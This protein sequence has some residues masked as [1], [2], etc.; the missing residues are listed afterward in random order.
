MD[1]EGRLSEVLSE[2]ART[3]VTDFPIQAILDH[4]VGRI[5]NVLPITAAGVTLI[6]AGTDPHY[7][8][9]SDESALRFEKLQT[10]LGQ[11]PCV[12]AFESGEAVSIPDLSKDERFPQF[13]SAAW[14]EGLRAIF[15][16]PLRQGE[17]QLGALDLYRSSVGS[18][19]AQAMAAAQ[20]LAD[21]ASAY[22]L[23]AQA[24]ADLEQ[25]SELAVENSL[26]D[27]LTGLPNRALLVQRLDHAILRCR[28]SGKTVA[29]LYADLD[30]FKAVN[31][32]YGHHVG[33]EL[34]IAVSERLGGLLRPGDTLAR[35]SGD[36]FVVL[37]EDLDDVSQVNPIADRIDLA[38]TVPFDLAGVQ[39]R[40]SAS[41]GIAFAG[42]GND[43]PETVLQEA[44]TAMYQVKRQGGARHGIIDVREQHLTRHKDGLI[45]DLRL[46]LT[47]DELEIVYQ[48]IVTTVGQDLRGVE[49]LLRWTHPRLGAIPAET[50]VRL[51]EESGLITEIGRWVLTRACT[52][53]H[54]LVGS[55]GD[56]LVAAVN[57]SAHQ[58]SAPDFVETVAA[59]LTDTDTQPHRLTLE[60]TE[61][62]FIRESESVLVALNALKDLGVMIALDD[63]GTGYS[64]LSYLKRFPVDIVKIDR[65]FIA[66]ICTE[67]T[68]RLIV[69]AIVELAHSLQ[70][71]VVAEG[72]ESELQRAE[73]ASLDCDAYQ[74]FHF[75]RPTS[76]SDLSD[77]LTRP[78]RS[79]Q[80]VGRPGPLAARGDRPHTR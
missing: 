62:V 44:D 2:F 75:A 48:P 8:A 37:C 12:A 28:R 32:T 54:G 36:E 65:T 50:I 7:I 51:A 63:F 38:L 56:E 4:L 19:D 30:D 77:W 1:L 78:V 59:V 22:L 40:V 68:S 23:N 35:L 67:P 16:F 34:L 21:V 52:D 76:R 57:V 15:T 73:V 26:H 79:R 74:G 6:S 47:R 45:R 24:R 42:Q 53:T 58:L 69:S 20:T 18:L 31:D 61:S 46:A 33:D 66:D 11:G 3:L 71:L 29:I 64:S 13:T 39:R 70:M 10:E 80:P 27:Q 17:N 14:D 60:L 55:D 43:V 9:A 49:A 5:V 41:V 25:S 72:V